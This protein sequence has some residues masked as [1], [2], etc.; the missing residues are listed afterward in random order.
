[1]SQ[2]LYIGVDNGIS[3]GFSAV[4]EAHGLLIDAIP[5]PVIKSG[6]RN[7]VNVREV[8][9]WISA[10]TCGNLSNATYVIEEPGGSKSAQAA[11]SM[12]GSFHAVRAIFDMKF[13]NWHRITPQKWQKAILGKTCG[14]TKQRAFVLAKEL[15]P[16]EKWLATTRCKTPHDGMIDAALI[17]EYARRNNL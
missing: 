2:L 11:R 16:E 6:K 14:D 15:W 5:M 7:E 1:M 4:S 8:F 13:L 17:A 9:H 12:A 10:V 3:G